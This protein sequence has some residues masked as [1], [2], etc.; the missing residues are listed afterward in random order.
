MP[1]SLPIGQGFVYYRDMETF[2]ILSCLILSWT[3][4]FI[5]GYLLG[6]VTRSTRKPSMFDSSEFKTADELNQYFIKAGLYPDSKAFKEAV[7]NYH[8]TQS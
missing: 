2:I 1:D 6:R 8:N 5:I 4:F 7:K 3:I